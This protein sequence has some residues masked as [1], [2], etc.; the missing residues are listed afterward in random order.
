MEPPL[1]PEIQ[2]LRAACDTIVA[3]DGLNPNELQA[4]AAIAQDLAK[5]LPR[6]EAKTISLAQPDR[7]SGF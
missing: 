1:R 2:V 5:M 6:Q 4:V 7:A 3:L